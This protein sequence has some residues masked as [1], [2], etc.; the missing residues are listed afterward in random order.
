LRKKGARRSW[1]YQLLEVR[2]H[3][4]FDWQITD[5]G[6]RKSPGTGLKGLVPGSKG[7]K[8]WQLRC[9]GW[10]SKGDLSGVSAAYKQ[11]I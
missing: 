2:E 9:S 7:G 10:G 5:V 3:V 11:S 4:A 6:K 1:G 8:G